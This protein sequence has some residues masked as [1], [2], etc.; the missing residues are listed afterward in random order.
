M[1]AAISAARAAWLLSRLKLRRR[2][3]QIESIYRYRMGSPERKA[4]SRSSPASFI[5]TALVGLSMLG[6]S[7]S[8]AYRSLNNMQEVLGAAEARHD[9]AAPALRPREE[10]AGMRDARPPLR[11]AA[12]E[13]GS[14]VARGVV[15]GATLEAMLL[16]AA[17]LL[18]TLAGREIVRLEWDLEWLATLP[19]PLSTLVLSRLIERAMTNPYGFLALGPF[20]SLLAWT[21]G[22]RWSAPLIGIALTLP[23]LFLVA[24]VHTLVDTGLRLALAP[25]R[26][27]NVQA[28]ISLVS[29]VPLLLAMSTALPGNVLVFGWAAS[30][31]DAA[32]WF[33]T[34]LAVRAIA[35]TDLAA[36][37]FLSAALV[38]QAGLAVAIGTALLMRQLRDGVAAAGARE[39][40]RL[41]RAARAAPDPR[42]DARLR[43]TVVQR[44]ELRLLGRDRTFMVQTL[45]LPAVIVGGQV[46][47]SAGSDLFSGAVENPSHLAAIAFA[48]A[49]YTLMFSAFQTLN[50]EGQALWILYCVP[51]SLESI[52][53]QKTALWAI[54][55]ALYPAIVF[56][57]AIAAAGDISLAFVGR[58]GVALAGVP[59]FAVIAAALGVFACDPLAHDVQR[60]VRATYLY[61]Y[62]MLAT[63]YA[64]AIYASSVW[65]R[66]ALMVLTTLVAVA[67]WQKARDQFDYLLDPSASPPPRVSVSDG[68]IAALLFF[69][70]QAM[71]ILGQAGTGNAV[72]TNALWI[73]FCI[74][75]AVTYGIVRLVYWRAGTADIPVIFDRGVPR[76]LLWGALGGVAASLVGLAYLA[77]VASLDLFP[78]LRR[79]SSLVYAGVPLWLAAVAIV[80]APIFEEFIFRGLIFRGLERSF[81]LA[82]AAL[83]SAA[84]FAMV[85]PP[86]AAVPVFVMGLAAAL[87]YWR[88]RMLAAPIALHAVY[89]AVLVGLQWMLIP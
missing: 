84:I 85:H 77:I 67:L 31:P 73:S 70:L 80:A 38:A 59:M 57:I 6:T 4:A 39:V 81:G 88:T 8:L 41:P 47:V 25:A 30:L 68:L 51:H 89:N 37:A 44:R 46:F 65:Q 10:M 87:V 45:L 19:L 62:M 71:V 24:T 28:A 15:Q 5:I 23:L 35:T 33:P 16:L 69:V 86:I 61:L 50:A 22:Y 42:K 52:L 54:F 63:F 78:E 66:V 2:L 14:A 34:A 26:L 27:R 21:C 18:L 29:M 60:R 40:V 3:N 82:V 79:A 32:R 43:A 72:G 1:T 17:A 64:Y 20:L 13:P 56:A 12:A 48:L 7:T 76:A 83:A 58:M 74:A 55:A 9:A 75:G 36:A 49:A 11:A 53:R